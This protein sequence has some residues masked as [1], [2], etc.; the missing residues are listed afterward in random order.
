MVKRVML[1]LVDHGKVL[2][3]W[4]GV[5]IQPIDETSAQALNLKTRNVSLVADVVDDGPAEKAGVETG[6]VI[7]EFN[8]VK[9]NNVDHLL[10][11]IHI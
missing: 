4:I 6:D 7:L 10:S 9:V 3:S 11:L 1:D 8:K 5:Q 2:R